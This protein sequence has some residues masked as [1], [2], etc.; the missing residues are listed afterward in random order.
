MSNIPDGRPPIRGRGA[1]FN[2]PVRFEPTSVEPFDDGWGVD[3]PDRPQPRTEI[4]T[5]RSRRI[6]T[7]NQS[8]DVPFDQSINPY[9]GCEHGCIYCYARPSHAH[10]G[11]SPGLYFETR[12][13][14]KPAA[15][16]LLERELARPGYRCRVIALGA[17]T[18]P[19][20]P[21]ERRLTITRRILKVLAAT[22]HPVGIVTKSAAVVRDLDLLGPMAQLGLASVAISITTLDR[23]LARRL[24][25]R[26]V[27]PH[28][29]LGAIAQ[30]RAAGVPAGV[31]V[32][33]IIPG[34]TDSEIE[35][36]LESA[37]AAGANHAGH[38]LIRLPREV[39][40]LFR[41]WLQTHAPGKADRVLE[42]IRQCRGGRLND[43]R[44]RHRMR[45]EGA[46]AAM[47]NKRFALACRQ[48]GFAGRSLELRTD[49][50]LPPRRSQQLSLL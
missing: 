22:R 1:S 37:R 41:T 26:A 2:P 21:V 47:L 20:Q 16:D 33:P 4:L 11:L 18:D 38:T 29:R 14:A 5:D 27:A 7:E 6:I 8:P 34:L 31:M 35:A 45:G 44:F 12:I 13:F 23:A 36:I 15:A 42:L 24:E 28:R 17:N 19:Y 39:G 30:L 40:E 10:W 48:L 3:D 43:P 50:F 9:L 25:P 32:A 46:Y 49:L